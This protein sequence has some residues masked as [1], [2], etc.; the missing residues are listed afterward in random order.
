GH[1]MERAARSRFPRRWGIVTLLLGVVASLV[2]AATGSTTAQESAATPVAPGELAAVPVGPDNSVHYVGV[3][4]G[5]D[6]YVAV[7]DRGFGLM[8]GYLCDGADVSVWLEGS[9][10]ETT[11]KFA[12]SATD[13]TAVEG[14]IVDDSAN[15][16]ATLADGSTKNFVAPKAVLPAGLYER[17]A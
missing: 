11:G 12:A 7:I 2:L 17:T 13:G 4:E 5:T 15:G 16:T 3:V 1:R 8:D 6:I 9:G 14:T 10:D